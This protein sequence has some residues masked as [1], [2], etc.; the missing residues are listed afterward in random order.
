MSR[1][2]SRL[3]ELR[4]GSAVPF[5]QIITVWIFL[6]E[7]GLTIGTNFLLCSLRAT[8][9][10]ARGTC[11]ASLWTLDQDS[12]AQK[13]PQRWAANLVGI[14][15]LWLVSISKAPVCFQV[16]L[17]WATNTSR[18]A[19]AVF[20]LSRAKVFLCLS[21]FW[22]QKWFRHHNVGCVAGERQSGSSEP[23]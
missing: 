5:A 20:F 2:A 21:C 17:W 3:M 11:C 19:A 15:K 23:L 6:S 18:D 7:C 10:A 14:Y 16:E 9:A 13:A 8:R 12:P 4:R 22:C 1:F